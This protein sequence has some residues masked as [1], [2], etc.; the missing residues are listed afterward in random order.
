MGNVHVFRIGSQKISLSLD[1]V[2][3]ASHS[4][5]AIDWKQLIGIDFY[6]FFGRRNF[7][8]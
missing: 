4:E 3:K 6:L 1:D 2:V 7:L 5:S 8:L